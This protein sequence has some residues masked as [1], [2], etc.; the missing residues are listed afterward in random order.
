MADLE[1]YLNGKRVVV[2]EGSPQLGY[3]LLQFLRQTGWAG[4][5]E[6]CSEGGCGACTVIVSH[7]D[8]AKKRPVHKSTASCLMPLPSVHRKNITTVEGLSD[9]APT[10]VHPICEA[11]RE[12]GA[13]QCGFC[14]PGFVMALEA[15]LNSEEKLEKKDLGR[16]YDGNLCRCTGYRPILDAAAVFCEDPLED[17][18]RVGKWRDDYQHTKRL[19]EI[20]PEEYKTP[21]EPLEIKGRRTNW[22][23]PVAKDEALRPGTQFVSGNTDIGYLEKYAFQHPARKTL[24]DGVSELKGIADEGNAVVIGAGV[25]IEELH[26][27]FKQSPDSALKALSNQC[28]YFANTQ[29][30]NHATLGGGII[31]FNSYGDLVPVWIATRA[32]LNFC[33]PDGDKQVKITGTDFSIPENA[34]LVSVTVPKAG[35]ETHVES[36][37]YARHRSDSITYVSGALSARFD[38]EKAH[39]P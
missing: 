38:P 5:K 16:L 18:P 24:L 9:L 27:T 32:T 11:F 22:H 36:Y 4:T 19:D 20:F 6:V 10:E 12:L 26:D 34:L 23:L 14:T 21:D 28:R 35:R 7:F 29:I 1:F 3:T 17:E 30:R 13:T 37:K 25:T 31:S 2:E 15:R 33:T 39:V 8:G